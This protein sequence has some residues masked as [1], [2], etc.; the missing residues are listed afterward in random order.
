MSTSAAAARAA[1]VQHLVD[2]MKRFGPVQARAMFGGHGLYREGLMFALVLDERLYFKVDDQNQAAFEQQGLKPFSYVTKVGKTGQ[3]RYHEAPAEAYEDMEAM[4]AWA[5]R[6]YEAAL[7][8]QAAKATQGAKSGRRK[9]TSSKGLAAGA[10]LVTTD[11]AALRNLGPA[12]QAMLARAGIRSAAQLRELGSVRAYLATRRVCG[13]QATLNLLWALEGA[14][15]DRPWQQVAET[16]RVSLLMAL[17][18]LERL[19]R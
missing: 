8:A 13:S 7:R 1:L 16:D 19:A 18:D 17:E 2:L 10:P 4:A 11:C 9:A 5:Q 3:L 6:G 15:S 14:L 12:S